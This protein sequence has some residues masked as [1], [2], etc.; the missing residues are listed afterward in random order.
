V[1][2]DAGD[3]DNAQKALETI[4]EKNPKD[5]TALVAL[6]SFYV[7]RKDKEKAESI[8]AK[9]KQLSPP[10]PILDAVADLESKLKEQV[11]VPAGAVD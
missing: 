9:V 7:D 3:F 10:Q 4:A 8:L 5:A 6:A 1:Y 2:E 11:Q